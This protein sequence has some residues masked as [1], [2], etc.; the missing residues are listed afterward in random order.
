MSIWFSGF[1]LDTLVL[2]LIKFESCERVVWLRAATW[3]SPWF[4][5]ATLSKWSDWLTYVH[6]VFF[7]SQ[8]SSTS[9][10]TGLSSFNNYYNCN[11]AWF[12]SCYSW[13]P[14]FSNTFLFNQWLP[15]IMINKVFTH[16][17]DEN[18]T[19]AYW[20]HFITDF[21]HPSSLSV[22][23]WKIAWLLRFNLPLAF[24]EM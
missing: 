16:S 19:F 12:W 1:S 2:S 21:T 15:H 14:L 23:L 18:N 11:G 20:C 9:C 7:F 8:Y 13:N 17:W 24:K 3:L 10:H 4:L 22:N 5:D 6:I